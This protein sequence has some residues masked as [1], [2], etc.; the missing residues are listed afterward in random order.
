MGVD[1][2]V[3]RVELWI[4]ARD[5]RLDRFLEIDNVEFCVGRRQG[6]RNQCG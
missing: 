5:R 1:F 6:S 3:E 4:V 2:L